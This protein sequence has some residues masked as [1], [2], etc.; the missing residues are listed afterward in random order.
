MSMS[1]TMKNQ[2]SLINVVVKNKTVIVTVL[3]NVT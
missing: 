2:R 3:H 1:M